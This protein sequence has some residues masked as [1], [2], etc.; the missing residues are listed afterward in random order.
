MKFVFEWHKICA[1]FHSKIFGTNMNELSG[2]D[3]PSVCERFHSEFRGKS[4]I[5]FILSGGITSENALIAC[6]VLNLCLHHASRELL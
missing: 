2:N 5:A 6:M 4:M 3:G 1:K